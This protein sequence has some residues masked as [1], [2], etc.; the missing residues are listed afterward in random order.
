MAE[1]TAKNISRKRYKFLILRGRNNSELL[2]YIRAKVF[3]EEQGYS[4][5]DIN[6]EFEKEATHILALKENK[7]VGTVTIFLESENG[8]PVEK[9]VDISIFK[10]KDRKNM[11]FSK[12]AVL[13]EE[14]KKF[15]GYNLILL[16]NEIA[17]KNGIKKV[18]F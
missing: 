4:M 16:T 8:L 6:I 18:F 14:R 7:P 1:P 11:F 10:A 9:F 12:L 15:I 5:N 13:K 17:R 3:F 2:F